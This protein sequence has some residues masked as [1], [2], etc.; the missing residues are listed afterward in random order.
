MTTFILVPGM[1]HGG[2]WYEPLAEQLR[3]AGH[4]AVPV[5]PSGLDPDFADSTSAINLDTHIAE[6]I[7]AIDGAAGVGRDVVLVGH[8]YAGSVITGAADVR[9][10]R[11]RALVYLDAFVPESGDTCWSMTNDDQ[12]RWYIDGSAETGIGVQPLPFF[13]DRAR[14]HP[15]GTLL[16][17]STLTGAWRDVPVKH[18]VVALDWPGGSPMAATA[19][20]V[21]ANSAFTVHE[22][23][24]SH[25]VLAEGPD[26]VR[27][28]IIEL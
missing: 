18:Y 14:P 11:V 23:N 12:R 13:D 5:T 6:V 8:S 22:W 26:R 9:A 19:A 4:V 20:R 21:R 28:L 2:W 10:Q 7:A 3:D 25:N 16:Q 24:T 17:R 1:C 27:E 15:I